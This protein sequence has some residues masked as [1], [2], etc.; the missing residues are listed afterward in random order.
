MNAP[1]FCAIPAGERGRSPLPCGW[2]L[3]VCRGDIYGDSVSLANI[4]PNFRRLVYA[5]RARRR[6]R[7]G[8]GRGQWRRAGRWTTCRRNVATVAS[9]QFRCPMPNWQHWHWNWQHFHIM[10]SGLTAKAQSATAVASAKEV[11][12]IQ[13][14]PDIDMG[15]NL[16]RRCSAAQAA[17]RT[18]AAG[19]SRR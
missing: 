12:N 10:T 11:G 18:R 1:R 16:L 2:W 4:I 3:C 13:N 17:A 6:G 14:R 15:I 7:E 9:I 5:R 8:A 19:S